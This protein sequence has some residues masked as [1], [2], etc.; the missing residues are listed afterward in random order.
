MNQ[1]RRCAMAA[2][3]AHLPMLLYSSVVALSA[4]PVTGQVELDRDTAAGLGNA[5]S[6][7]RACVLGGNG[8]T[9]CPSE[10]GTE[11]RHR[12]R[13]EWKPPP[14]GTVSR[15]EVYRY[16]VVTGNRLKDAATRVPL[17]GTAETPSCGASATTSFI[18]SEQIPAGNVVYF[19]VAEFDD[20][21]RSGPSNFATITAVD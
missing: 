20:R 5:P 14:L 9:A 4:V 15:Y 10:Y 2:V 17:C 1:P 8:V 19:V 3:I 13:L 11:P 7:L 18:D 6:T 16:R 12:I 21:T